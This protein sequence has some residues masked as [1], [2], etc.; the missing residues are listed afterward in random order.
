MAIETTYTQARASL[1]ALCDAV[2]D[3][4]ETVIIHRRG[5]EDV[6]LIAA[7][8]LRSLQ[9]TAH[10]LRSPTNAQRLLRSLLRSLQRT[11]SPSRVTDMRIEEGIGESD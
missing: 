9:E 4:Q 6:A 1:A 2:T 8:E 10:L 3:D 7:A 11:E 5:A